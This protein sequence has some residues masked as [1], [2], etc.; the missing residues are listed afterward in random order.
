MR[1]T[2][3]RRP[4]RRDL[5]L[6]GAHARRHGSRRK[7]DGECDDCQYRGCKKCRRNVDGHLAQP[8]NVIGRERL[9]YPEP[10][11]RE[12]E[13]ATRAEDAEHGG[14]GQ[15]LPNHVAARRTQ[16]EA[17]RD[18]APPG[19]G[20]QQRHDRDVDARNEEHGRRRRHHQPERHEHAAELGLSQGLRAD[21]P[22]RV[23]CIRSRQIVPELTGDALQVEARSVRARPRC[24]SPDHRKVVVA[25]VCIAA[26]AHV[27][28]HPGTHVR[29]GIREAGGHDSNDGVLD[30]VEADGAR[31]DVVD[32]TEP[33]SPQLVAQHGNRR[34]ALVSGARAATA[35]GTDAEDRKKVRGD[36]RHLDPLGV[37]VRVA[38]RRQCHP[39]KV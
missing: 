2:A 7:T 11:L 32:T 15:E 23:R 28:R 4:T 8:R 33:R 27:D 10:D 36:A 38:G 25:A 1:R 39:P 17:D 34:A 5:S 9:D 3:V 22:P 21:V 37:R 29:L 16:R 35:R 24:Q 6:D 12:E 20:A 31:E 18:L 14:L 13:S 30:A 19:D 26:R